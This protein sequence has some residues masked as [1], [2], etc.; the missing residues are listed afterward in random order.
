MAELRRYRTLASDSA[1]WWDFPFRSDDIIVSP[2]AKA[3]TTWAQTLV[4]MLV[5]DTD[6]FDQPLSDISPYFDMATRDRAEVTAMLE[7]QRHRRFIK[8]HTPLDGL[9]VHE[10][11]TYLTVGRDPRDAFLSLEHHMANADPATL[12]ELAN[13]AGLGPEALPNPPEDPLERFWQW[14]DGPFADGPTVMPATL[15]N[16]LH[17]L[18]TFWDQRD[19]PGVVLLH[20]DDLLADLPGQ[21]RRLAD[22]L[23]IEV[24]DARIGELAAAA[25]FDNMRQRYDVLTPEVNRRF[26]RDDRAFFHSGTSGQWRGLLDEA[27]VRRYEARVAELVPPD[28]ADWVHS[29]WL[30]ARPTAASTG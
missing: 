5:F 26:W 14:A 4:A 24:S 30:G 22:A 20:Y 3:G 15:V 12:L 13:S 7:A 18:Q 21:L 10:G 19:R 27:G 25:T 2:P 9:P 28:L 16:F 23:A 6:R 17:H 29:G 1:S 11:V 8:T